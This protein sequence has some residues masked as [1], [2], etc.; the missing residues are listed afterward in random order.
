MK[1]ILTTLSLVLI[2]LCLGFTMAACE[3]GTTG[4]KPGT[5]KI[6]LQEAGY[7]QVYTLTAAKKKVDDLQAAQNSKTYYQ[8]LADKE[9]DE[10]KKENYL[11][12]VEEADE[13][14]ASLNVELANITYL[15]SGAGNTTPYGTL[16]TANSFTSD[17]FIAIKG[18]KDAAERVFVLAFSSNARAKSFKAKA[19]ADKENFGD[20]KVFMPDEAKGHWVVLGLKDFS[21]IYSW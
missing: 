12:K 13:L 4:F 16:F 10:T 19:L 7:S 14:I 8:N 15:K 11:K 20:N 21:G 3:G 9:I 2:V 17:S 1:K 6:K 5:A 18:E